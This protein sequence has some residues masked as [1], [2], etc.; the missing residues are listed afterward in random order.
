MGK[1]LTGVRSLQRKLMPDI[2]GSEQHK[3]TSLRGIANLYPEVST[4]EEPDAGKSHVRVCTGDA[5]QPA[6]LPQRPLAPT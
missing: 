6:S 4:T 3:L 5:G 2:V 1:D